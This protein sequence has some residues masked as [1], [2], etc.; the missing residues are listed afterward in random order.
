MN[1]QI[2]NLSTIWISINGEWFDVSEFEIICQ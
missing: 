2:N 1:K